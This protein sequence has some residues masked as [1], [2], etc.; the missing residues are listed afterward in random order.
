MIEDDADEVVAVE[1][2]AGGTYRRDDVRALAHLRDRLGDRFRG[3]VLMYTGELAARLDDRVYLV[4]I[5][6]LWQEGSP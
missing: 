2:K 3:G 5:D 6:N 4:P 1:V